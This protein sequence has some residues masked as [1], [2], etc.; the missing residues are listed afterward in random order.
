[1]KSG[2]KYVQGNDCRLDW[3]KHGRNNQY[4]DYIFPF[5]VHLGESIAGDYADAQQEDDRK[6]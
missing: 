3:N 5:K 4:I 6:K 1:M 2:K